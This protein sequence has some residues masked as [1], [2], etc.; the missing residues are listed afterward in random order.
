MERLRAAAQAPD[1]PYLQRVA[2]VARQG[3]LAICLGFTSR[4]GDTIRNSAGLW[5]ADGTLAGL[6]HKTHLQSHD[7]Q[8]T[9][10][11]SLPVFATPWGPLG[12]MICADRRSRCLCLQGARLILNPT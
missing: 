12:V 1:S 11:D 9:A 6:Y 5:L 4:E 3:A 2:E 7:L 8:Y 10:G